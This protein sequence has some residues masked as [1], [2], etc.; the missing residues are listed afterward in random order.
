MPNGEERQDYYAG[1]VG[2]KIADFCIGLFGAY[3][4]WIAPFSMAAFLQTLGMEELLVLVPVVALVLLIGTIV[5]CF[6]IGRRYIAIGIMMSI[7]LPILAVGACFV[8]IMAAM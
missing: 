4:L 8:L 5:F 1:N 3:V 2:L 6:R 7:F